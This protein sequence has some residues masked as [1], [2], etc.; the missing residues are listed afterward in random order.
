V[1]ISAVVFKQGNIIQIG[2]ETDENPKFALVKDVILNGEEILLGCQKIHNIGF[3]N[4]F[5][6]YVVE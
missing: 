3:D 6:A 1:E 5:Y 2:T 4:H